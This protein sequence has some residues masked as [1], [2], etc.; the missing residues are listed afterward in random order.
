[1]LGPLID[2]KSSDVTLR[3][4]HTADL[5]MVLPIEQ[6]AQ[7]SPWARLSFEEALTKGYYCRALEAQGELL[8]YHIVSAV[9]DELH[10]LNV[11]CAPKAQG[12]GLGHML[13]QDMI[14]Y[15]KQRALSKLFLEV[16]AS[17]RIAQGLY[18]KWGFKQI[19]VRKQYYRPSVSDQ[20]RED[21]LVYLCELQQS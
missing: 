3:D 8:A 15:A 17:N 6:A 19:G 13:M 18:H 16:R 9:M 4:L 21:A 5:T 20:H 2:I 14:S 12:F 7:V 10:I 1:M 11:T